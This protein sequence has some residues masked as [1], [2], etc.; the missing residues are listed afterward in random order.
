MSR[1]ALHDR[2]KRG[3][4]LGVP[5][6]GTTWF[7]TW[8][9]DLANRSSRP[10]VAALLQAFR[11]IDLPL[12]AVEIASW[13]QRPQAELEDSHTCRLGRWRPAR[14]AGAGC[15][16]PHRR[17]R[18]CVTLRRPPAD[19]SA[20]AA[21]PVRAVAETYPYARIHLVTHEPEWF[22]SCGGH[23]FDPPRASSPA[24]GTC[25]LA[26][27]PVGAFVEKFGDLGIVEPRPRRRPPAQLPSDPGGPL[28]RFH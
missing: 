5:G 23:R 13:A 1:Q 2:V 7:P 15:C 24:F 19:S 27:Q 6:R 4:L 10:V 20:L 14:R 25:Y 12:A 9:F 21:F 22:C 17:A 16:A 26:G 28:S 3:T 11:S 18:R 8:Q